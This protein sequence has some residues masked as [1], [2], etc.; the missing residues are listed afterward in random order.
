MD[1]LQSPRGTRDIL[2]ED[3]QYWNFI[4]QAV[5]KKA[6]YFGFDR[7]DLPMFENVKTFTRSIGSG[8]DIVEKELYE[9]KRFSE[10]QSSLESKNNFALRPEGTAG[11]VRAYIQ[12]GMQYWTQPI[13]LWYLGSM[14]RYD[15]PQKGRYREFQSM[16]A[17]LIGDESPASDAQIILLAW[18]VFV[19]LGLDNNLI[20]DINTIGDDNCRP[21]IRK[22]LVSYYEN[23]YQDLCQD[24]LNRLKSNPLRLLDCKNESCNKIK[25]NAPQTF[26]LVDENCKKNFK[27]VLEYL[28]ELNIPYDLNPSLV[29]GLDYY[30]RTTFEFRQKEDTERQ[31][32]LGGGGRYDGL[33][34]LLGGQ[35]TPAVGFGLGL[36]RMVELLK[37]SR[38]SL[39]NENISQVC[40]I[41]LGERAKLI[42]VSLIQEITRAGFKVTFAPQKDSL[43]A[44]LRFAN[45]VNS[46]FALIIGQKEALDNT[47]IVKNL[48]D[49]SQE[50]I[51]RNKLISYFNKKLSRVN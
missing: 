38:I 27:E 44:Q 31:S 24:C 49:S 11:V 10:K 2:P 48:D 51:S 13:K 22:A 36:D 35:P 4:R 40:L 28:D 34:E 17:E 5:A 25:K 42:A 1:S 23:N 9:V 39:P 20:V 15:R 3:Q 37:K 47:I 33:V 32:A 14:F 46:A 7:I 6:T 50:I 43:K 18:E 8:T 30:T 41:S 16:G 12:N 45:K 19:E 29:R 26:D 21:K